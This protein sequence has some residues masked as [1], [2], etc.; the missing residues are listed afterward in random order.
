MP[1]NLSPTSTTSAIILTSTGSTSQVTAALPIGAYTAS[2]EFI[3][4]A[5]A[6]VSYVYKKL[7]GDVL[8]I[9]YVRHFGRIIIN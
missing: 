4:G 7:G 2:A 5:A 8:D 3:S 6:Q 1:Q 9:E